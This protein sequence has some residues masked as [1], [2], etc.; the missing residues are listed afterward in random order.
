MS[1]VGESSHNVETP[2]NEC[3]TPPP[4]LMRKRKTTTMDPPSEPT[5]T[6]KIGKRKQSTSFTSAIDKLQSIAE[7]ATQ[8]QSDVVE[9]EYE[10]FGRHIAAQLRKLPV[11]SFVV[12]QQQMQN[13]IA[14][15]RLKQL[16]HQGTIQYHQCPS[17]VDSYYSSPQSITSE[18]S[19]SNDT[20][21]V[22]EPVKASNNDGLNLI[23][24]AIFN[25]AQN[26]ELD[27][28]V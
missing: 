4:A 11:R 7:L 17:N 1:D 15:E 27:N 10:R 3:N 25:I 23:E 8:H 21:I 5:K 28:N 18:Q 14:E 20:F 12:L 16:D 24:R 9:D 6:N 2:S 22:L 13:S 19:M 26:E